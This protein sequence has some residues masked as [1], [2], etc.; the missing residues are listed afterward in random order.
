MALSGEQTVLTQAL[1]NN[2][3]DSLDYYAYWKTFDMAAETAFAGKDATTLR[4]DPKFV[5]MGAWSDGW[6]MR[7]LSAEMPR[8]EGQDA[9]PA[10]G[11]RRVL[12]PPS[13]AAPR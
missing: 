1:G 3:T 2:V 4:S 11:P 7:R 12:P 6:P 9:K 13:A 10:P 5:D 8:A